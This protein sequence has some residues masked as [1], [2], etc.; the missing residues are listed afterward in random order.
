MSKK[1]LIV[2]DEEFLAQAILEYFEENE[3]FEISWSSSAN[4]AR[5]KIA[6]SELILLDIIMPGTDGLELLK[7]IRENDEQKAKKIIMLTNLDRGEERERA[8]AL[9]I[10]DYIVKSNIDLSVL[11]EQIKGYLSS[12]EVSSPQEDT[13]SE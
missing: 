5:E 6:E 9:G 13:Q 12:E 7:E 8:E 3:E 2:E 10:T 11:A 4:E 1:I